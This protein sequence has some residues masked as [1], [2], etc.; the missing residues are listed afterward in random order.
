MS[1]KNRLLKNGLASVFQKGVRVLEQLFLVP[2]FLTAWGAAYYGEWLT[3]TIIPSVI[4]F[5]DLGFGTAAANSFVLNYAAGKKQRAANISKTGM[6][7]ITIMVLAAIAI[8]TFSI[9]ILDYFEVFDKT[10][11]DREEAI[12][13]VSIL[14]LTRL[15]GFYNQLI[16]SYYIAAQKASLSINFRTLVGIV[17]IGA[18]L[19]VL[20]SGYGIV[21]YAFSQLF[22]M[23]IF[24][25]FYW[26]KGRSLLALFKSFKGEKDRIIIKDIT[27]KGFG[28]LMSPVWQSIYFQGTT[29][30]V[31]IVL[32]PEAV[33]IFNTARTLSRSVNQLLNIISSSIF[34]ELQYE[35][36]QGN[37]GKAQK[38]YRFSI[39]TSFLIALIGVLF[40]AFFGLWFYKLWTQNELIVSPLM[41]YIFVVGILFHAFWWSSE[42]VFR[43]KNEPYKFAFAGLIS[44]IVSV[45]LTYFLAQW[46]NL[47]GAALGTI[48]LDLLMAIIILPISAN[49]LQ[50]KV[51]D[52]FSK[53]IDE[54]QDVYFFLKNRFKAL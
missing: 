25:T 32:G 43:A 29:F 49:M 41:W 10:L 46:Y 9:F 16:E 40:L 23:V 45:F 42:P 21:E 39:V 2:F 33:A 19:L 3:L 26:I 5:S 1:L 54:I 34:P 30:A 18:G 53:G 28:Y 48:V 7:I 17:Y 27:N 20:L 15:F 8:S 22:V 36:G 38:I 24:N 52:V 44:A 31:R 37:V 11:I 47:E 14:I 51:R 50:M 4:A 6:Y 13:A 35:I 12:W